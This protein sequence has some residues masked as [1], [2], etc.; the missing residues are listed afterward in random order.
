MPEYPIFRLFEAVGSVTAEADGLYYRLR[1]VLSEDL[2]GFPRLY[3]HRPGA[4][5][6]L[7]LFSLSDGAMRCTARIS[8]RMLG[9]AASGRFSVSETPWF[10]SSTYPG[11]LEQRMGE[12]TEFLFSASEIPSGVMPKFCFL[13]PAESS[14]RK[15]LFLSENADGTPFV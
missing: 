2:P 14:G 4:S 11:A 3:F 7:G 12:Q 6:R 1:A 5:L 8:A 13:R 9:D 15:I 10:P